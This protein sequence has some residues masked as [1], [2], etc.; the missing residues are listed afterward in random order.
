MELYLEEKV[1][2]EGSPFAFEVIFWEGSEGHVFIS[3]L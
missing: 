1:K 3:A 2:Y